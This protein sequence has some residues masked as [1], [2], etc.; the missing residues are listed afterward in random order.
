MNGE[1]KSSFI[2]AEQEINSGII[3]RSG[4]TL[5]TGGSKGILTFRSLPDL[6]VVRTIMLKSHG[7]VK[8]ISFTPDG[9]HEI[10]V[11][12][13]NGKIHV[14]TAPSYLAVERMPDLL[15]ETFVG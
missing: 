12:S 7:P 1:R 15:A 10:I 2:R 4:R 5:I 6:R 8:S 11:S 13:L 9:G 14:V 3:S